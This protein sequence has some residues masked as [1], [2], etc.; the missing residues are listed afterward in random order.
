MTKIFIF[1]L[2]I[3]LFSAKVDAA[4]IDIYREILVKNSYT[5]RYENLTPAPRVTNKDRVELYGKSGLSV[6]ANDY[7][8][9]R[10]KNGVITAENQDKYEEIGFDDFYICRLSKNG[11]DYFF[12]K[13]RK[14]TR[15]TYVGTRRNRVAAN[16]KNY[17]AELLEG[18]SY[19][20]SDMTR[21]LNAILPDSVK[22]A[23]Q[24]KYKFV[25]QGKISSGLF[26]EDFRSDF[27]GITEVVR[28]YFDENKLVKIASA[29]YY[30]NGAGKIDGRKCIIKIQEFSSTPDRNFLKLPEGVKDET[31]RRKIEGA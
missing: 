22:S 13:Y 2:L 18:K 9:D 24:P 28:Y 16:E 10:P 7:L 26:Y 30:K 23:Q 6:E 5:I 8:T 4:R 20:D 12:S 25:A 31:K 3:F 29:S 17:L 1:A 27:D 14:G 11:E 21:L 19:G 15:W